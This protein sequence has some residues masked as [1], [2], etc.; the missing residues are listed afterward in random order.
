LSKK[1]FFIPPEVLSYYPSV[2]EGLSDSSKDEDVVAMR[3]R[4]K[5]ARVVPF[6]KALGVEK[7]KVEHPRKNASGT[8]PGQSS[9]LSFFQEA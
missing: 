1:Y 7:P 5:S 3:S 9:L 6:K 4:S 2:L 8:V